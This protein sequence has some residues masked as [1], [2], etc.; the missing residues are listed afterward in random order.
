[1]VTQQV[2]QHCYVCWSGCTAP[3]SLLA[4]VKKLN[5]V[6]KKCN[7]AFNLII[8]IILLEIPCTICRSSHDMLSRGSNDFGIDPEIEEGDVTPP[9]ISTGMS[10]VRWVMISD[11]HHST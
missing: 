8:C 6:G 3:T 11:H 1:M 9:V 4:V 10:T 5:D 7:D 2:V